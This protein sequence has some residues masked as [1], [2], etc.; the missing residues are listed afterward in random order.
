MSNS[1]F[2]AEG[3]SL[4]FVT[5]L[6]VFLQ[7][8]RQAVAININKD[9]KIESTAGTNGTWFVAFALGL[10]GLFITAGGYFG[11]FRITI[12]RKI[13]LGILFTLGLAIT[14]SGGF[15]I[16]DGMNNKDKLKT[17]EAN[18]LWFGVVHLVFGFILCLSLV[19]MILL[20]SNSN[21]GKSLNLPPLGG[22]SSFS[23]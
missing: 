4:F 9:K 21:V 23:Q 18:R 19:R 20:K 5:G 22:G 11:A 12:P 2:T 3:G 15:Y 8:V 17:I 10:I 6:F 16:Y 1:N 13:A 7:A 14:M